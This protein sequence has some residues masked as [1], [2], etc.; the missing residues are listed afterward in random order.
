M[1]LGLKALGF[2][3]QKTHD[4]INE[5]KK[6]PKG[7]GAEGLLQPIVVRCF[8]NLGGL[9][10]CILGCTQEGSKKLNFQLPY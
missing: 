6:R 7:V 3:L 2:G 9:R 10:V 5:K 8:L 1:D 4:A